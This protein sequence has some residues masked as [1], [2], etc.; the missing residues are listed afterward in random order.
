M[1]IDRHDYGPSPLKAP[2]RQLVHGVNSD[3][4]QS[5]IVDGRVVMA[6]RRLTRVDEAAL[7]VPGA[8]AQSPAA[9]ADPDEDPPET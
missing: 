6:D 1:L 5:L 7:S 2:L 4:T 9:T 3:A 8:K